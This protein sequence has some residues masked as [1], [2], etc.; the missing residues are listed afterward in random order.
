MISEVLNNA[1]NEQIKYEFY[2]AHLYLAMA[3]YCESQDL[4]GFANFFK[5]QYQEENSHAMK[6]FDY[7]N[8]RN[9]RVKLFSLDEPKNEYASVLETFMDGY[10]H[11]QVVTKRI[12][13]LSDLAMDER[14][15][16]T[17]SFL[18]W[19]IDEQVEEES[20][21]DSIIK[22]LTRIKDDTSALYN[23]DAELAARVY[24]PPTTAQA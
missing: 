11:E 23:L 15:H 9:G 18:K 10:A 12:Y 6:F 4:P 3:A 16:A 8:Q 22:K 2:S 7:I 13:N 19:F 5:V 1:I 17:M 21:F 24:V 20:N 14:D